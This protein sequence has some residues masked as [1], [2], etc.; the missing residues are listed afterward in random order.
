MRLGNFSEVLKVRVHA[1]ASQLVWGRRLSQPNR[2]SVPR[3]PRRSASSG[4]RP[5]DGE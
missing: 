3:T 4:S 1:P 2:L 5:R